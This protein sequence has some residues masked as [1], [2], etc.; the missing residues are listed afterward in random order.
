MFYSSLD[1][2]SAEICIQ[3]KQKASSL[4]RCGI[5]KWAVL[6]TYMALI[7]DTSHLAGGLLQRKQIC[8]TRILSHTR[9]WNIFDY[10]QLSQQ[11]QLTLALE[12]ESRC[13]HYDAVWL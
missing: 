13:Q 12:L 11:Q 4:A 5:Q 3:H 8:S 1:N 2:V 10:M 9:K 7:R 6:S